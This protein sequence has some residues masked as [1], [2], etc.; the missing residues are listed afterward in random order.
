M[1]KFFYF[2]T[3]KRQR[4]ITFHNVIADNLYDDSLHLAV[5]CKKSVFITQLDIIE[6]FFEITT[7]IGVPNSFIITFDDGYFNNF[8]IVN[9]ILNDRELKAIFF[10]TDNLISKKEILWIDKLL[11]WISYVPINS[12]NILGLYLNIKNDNRQECFKRVYEYILKN[13]NKKD[14]FILEMESFVALSSLKINF[15]LYESRFKPLTK[16][17]IYEMKNNGHL[18]AIHSTNHDILSLLTTE[19]LKIEIHKCEQLLSSFY[20]CNYFSYPFGGNLE[21]SNKVKNVL[22]GSLF[23]FAFMN[24]WKWSVDRDNYSIQRISLPDTEN[25]YLINAHLSGL[26][27]FLKYI[28]HV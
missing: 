12:Y 23:K 7:E 22:S 20:N 2:I 5:S 10:I 27:Y 18:I 17:Q 13:Y 28:F 4:I 3:K 8:S 21:V 26:Y 9:S 1:N 11:L 24:Q 6:N 25:K 15:E 14:K 16:K 19:E